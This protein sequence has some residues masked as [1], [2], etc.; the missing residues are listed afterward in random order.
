[1]YT[2]HSI[3]RVYSVDELLREQ[4]E[5]ECGTGSFS[6]ILQVFLTSLDI[7]LMNNAAICYRWWV[8]E[9]IYII[10]ALSITLIIIYIIFVLYH[11]ALPVSTE[12][13]IRPPHV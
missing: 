12:L 11:A 5:T 13:M 10:V 6:G 8:H 9:Y 7:D 2:V 1:M 4:R 3:T